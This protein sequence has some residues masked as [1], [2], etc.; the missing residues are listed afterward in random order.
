MISCLFF[1]RSPAIVIAYLMRTYDVSLEQC[2]IH[3]IK[4]RPCVSPNDGFLKQLILFDRFGRHSK[5]RTWTKTIEKKNDFFFVQWNSHIKSDF[6]TIF[7]SSLTSDRNGQKKFI[8]IDR[9]VVIGVERVEG[10]SKEAKKKNSIDL[11]MR[12]FTC[13]IRRLC[14]EDRVVGTCQWISFCLIFYLDNRE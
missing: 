4:A 9:S 13:K 5:R 1:S 6:E 10:V 3:V 2:L 14:R 8:K 12:R 7:E 11:P